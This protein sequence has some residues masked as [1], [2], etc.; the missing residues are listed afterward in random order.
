VYPPLP[1]CKAYPIAILL[2]DHCAIYAPPTDP[3]FVC[4]EQY[5]IGDGNI[6]ST[7]TSIRCLAC[8]DAQWCDDPADLGHASNNAINTTR[9]SEFGGAQQRHG[10]DELIAGECARDDDRGRLREGSMALCGERC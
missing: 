3:P 4:R 6:V 1:T 2:H 8:E 9:H 7:P 10:L 5:N